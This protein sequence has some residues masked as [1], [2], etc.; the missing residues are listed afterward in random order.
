MDINNI[1]YILKIILNFLI[2]GL[3]IFIIVKLFIFL[4]PVILILIL[5]YY[6]YLLYKNSKF[7]IKEVK[8]NKK[9]I[10]PDAE[11]IDEKF[12]K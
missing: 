11:V 4:L 2:V 12:D 10:V 7:K 5:G 9:N 3:I 8:E 6:I 1:K